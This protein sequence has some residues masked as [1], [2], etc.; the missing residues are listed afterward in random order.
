MRHPGDADGRAQ[1]EGRFPR[2]SACASVV[3]VSAACMQLI[4]AP[5]PFISLP[6]F[7]FGRLAYCCLATA[8]LFP[9]VAYVAFAAGWNP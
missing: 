4:L 8:A 3:R 9:S 1:V 7:A 6:F 2:L 5:S